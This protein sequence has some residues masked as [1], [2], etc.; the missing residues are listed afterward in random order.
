MKYYKHISSINVIHILLLILVNINVVLSQS[1]FNLTIGTELDEGFPL[2]EL[3]DDAFILLYNQ[4]DYTTQPERH[5][6]YFDQISYEGEVSNLYQ[7][8]SDT[9]DFII[10][11]IKKHNQ[12][13]YCH[14]LQKHIDSTLYRHWLFKMDEY[15]QIEWEKTYE[16][17]FNDHSYQSEISFINEEII[18]SSTNWNNINNAF[19]TQFLR[20]DYNGNFIT[21]KTIDTL[22]WTIVYDILQKHT[23]N[24]NSFYAFG[25]GFNLP[26]P[27]RITLDYQFNIID[28]VQTY[29]TNEQDAEWITD[30]TILLCGSG[31]HD[32]TIYMVSRIMDTNMVAHNEVMY[33][34]SDSKNQHVCVYNAFSKTEEINYYLGGSTHIDLENVPSPTY[35]MLNKIDT[36][37][38]T[39][40]QKFYGGDARYALY[41]MRT[42]PDGGCIMTG[43]KYDYMNTQ[44]NER[45]IF[46]MKVDENG[47]ITSV[48][49][50]DFQV[51]D[52]IV[53]PNPGT[54]TLH[55]QSAFLL[56]EIRMMDING[57]MVL[58]QPLNNLMDKINVSPLNA[59]TYIYQIIGRDDEIQHG[60]WIK[61]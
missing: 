26:G 12:S 30:S 47:L 10:T 40:W 24:I 14:G 29:T 39:H 58:Q 60:K 16:S 59:G 38:N 27:V 56:K 31:Y 7:F 22:K 20:F 52:A 13:Y 32:D 55:I 34:H 19:A 57:R 4:K 21:E 61:M 5:I 11:T 2:I 33:K 28:E 46:V 17:P 54:N 1:T 9:V 48:D 51:A 42:T 41:S 25:M 23:P 50:P 45:D 37:L 49:N 8:S 6:A 3:S 43:Y 36:A 15:M 53:Y 44:Y 18:I 35:I